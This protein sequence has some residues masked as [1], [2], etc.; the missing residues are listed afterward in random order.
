MQTLFA[1]TKPGGRLFVHVPVNSPAPDHLFLLRSPDEARV[2]VSRFGFD[3]AVAHS[4]PGANLTLDRAIATGSTI[5]CVFVL[6]KPVA[7]APVVVPPP[8]SRRT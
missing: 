6:T 5:S 2:F 3:V 7:P 8:A 1:I 4:F